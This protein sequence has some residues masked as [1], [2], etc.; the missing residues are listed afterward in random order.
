MLFGTGI[1]YVVVGAIS[2]ILSAIFGAFCGW[3]LFPTLVTMNVDKV[4]CG[5]V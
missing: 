2:G 1:S 5:Y 4:M 3:V